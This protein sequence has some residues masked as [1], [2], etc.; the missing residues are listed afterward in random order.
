MLFLE[1]GLELT[2]CVAAVA[3][4]LEDFVGHDE[5]VVH[6]HEAHRAVDC[7]VVF[8]LHAFRF[9][10][11]GVSQVALDVAG[12]HVLDLVDAHIAHNQVLVAEFGIAEA[13]VAGSEK[14][15][16]ALSLE[17]GVDSLHVVA[18]HEAVGAGLVVGFVKETLAVLVQ[19]VADR[20]FGLVA[21]FDVEQASGGIA[22]VVLPTF[23]IDLCFRH[24]DIHSS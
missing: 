6:R 14:N 1:H 17:D 15:V 5:G 2:A 10:H 22:A 19:L 12:A 11:F 8:H 9:F 24:F 23:E 20:H 18:A 7:P 21:G 3:P 4:F 13:F 16:A